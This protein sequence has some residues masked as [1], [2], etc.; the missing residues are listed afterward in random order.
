MNPKPDSE[1][2]KEIFEIALD[3]ASSEE[4]RS[5]VK[6]VCDGDAELQAR[7]QTLLRVH[8]EGES[9]FLSLSA[10]ALRST[11]D[12]FRYQLRPVLT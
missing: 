8:F 12:L 3:L 9:G 4:R 10:A 2:V 5:Y 11:T 7:V 1:R 6:G